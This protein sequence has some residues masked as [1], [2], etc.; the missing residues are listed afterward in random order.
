MRKYKTLANKKGLKFGMKKD[1][2]AKFRTD[3]NKTW[4]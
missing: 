3:K 1:I 4:L 2:Y